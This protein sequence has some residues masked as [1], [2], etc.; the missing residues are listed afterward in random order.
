MM[1]D[2]GIMVRDVDQ[3]RPSD[4]SV[5][6][7]VVAAGICGTDVAIISGDLAV[8]LPLI[9]GHEFT[10]Y[11]FQ[12]GRNVK[13][14]DVGSRVTSEINLA[15][16]QCFFCKSNIPTQCLARKATGIDVNGAFAEYIAVPAENVHSLP[17]SVSYEEGVF[18]EPLAAAI[19]TMRMSPVKP[20]DN[21]VVIGDGRLGQLV[22]QAIRAMAPNVR[23]LMLGMHESKL[24][25]A[26]R[27]ATLDSTVN[28]T[29]DDPKEDCY[30]RDER[31]RRRYR[32]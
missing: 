26:K 30:E 15:C 24:A 7:R 12:V 17:K 28:V 1:T 18:I 5:L 2:K 22:V 29:N 16:G 20:T 6:V 8:P 9:L 23:L 19:Q 21:V 10:G 11:V 14:V 25:I 3:P 27:L 32:R 31:S 4:E 13:K